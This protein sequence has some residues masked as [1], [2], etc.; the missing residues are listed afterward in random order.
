MQQSIISKVV[1][2]TLIKWRDL[3]FIQQEDF[4]EWIDTGD[5]KLLESLLKY[6]FI[7]PFKVWKEGDVLWCLDG[8][9]RYLDLQELIKAGIDVP[10]EL[11][12]TFI[13]CAGKKEAAELVLVYS[14]I[15]ARISQQGMYEF[16]NNYDI[17]LSS[18][19]DTLEIPQFDMLDL[20][21]LINGVGES[22]E[23]AR[24]SLADKFIIP[25]FSIFDTRRG[26]W[27]DRK[28]SWSKL[29]DSQ[30]TRED[31]ELI[32]KSGQGPAVYALRNKM[33]EIL[34]R[35]PEWDEIIAEAKK[36]GM[37]IYEGASIF[38]PVL[39]EICYKWFCPAGGR[40][41]DPFA[42]GS[43]RGIV[44][45]L[46]DF[47]YVGID[48]RQDQVES[49]F[50]QWKKLRPEPSSNVSWITGDSNEV[51][52]EPGGEQECDF[53]FSCPPYH[54]LE[55]YSDDPKDL[56]NMNYE[57]FIE[58]YRSIILK[59]LMQLKPNRFAC[60]VVGD[61][62]D[63]E[64]KYRNFV[65]DTIDAFIGQPLADGVPV[66]L[67]NEIILVNVAGSLPVRIGRQ[68]GGYRKV[69]K[70]HQNVLVFFKGDP[71]T[72]KNEFPEI[73]VP[74]ELLEENSQ[75]AEDENN[76]GMIEK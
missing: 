45:G 12:A 65:S 23:V 76:I 62:R 6:N 68:F 4:K 50:K 17:D 42:G 67:Y 37:H 59:S 7:D 30:E 29:F 48:L 8:Y 35:E 10:E 20:A 19:Q 39:T 21:S 54:D 46:L 53:I 44:A 34:K 1:N 74:M 58:I 64:G 32:A 47:R 60:F 75:P 49:N 41:M 52:S 72:I 56:S 36:R 57:E 3:Q 18:I 27:Q 16:I 11:P 70:M 14:S 61:I 43:V 13:E 28:R 9:H 38:D 66:C 51:L 69:G 71:K 26:L 15:Y 2:T 55:K 33:R 63:K 25:P 22:D 24:P 73:V 40:I 31:V 5:K